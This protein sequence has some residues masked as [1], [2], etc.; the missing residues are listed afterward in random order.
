M[1]ARVR[2][3]ASPRVSARAVAGG[4]A[5]S[6][7]RAVEAALALARARVAAGAIAIVLALAAAVAP[8]VAHAQP[9]QAPAPNY[10]LEIDAPP[11]LVEPLRRQTLAGRWQNEPGFDAAQIELFVERARDEARA[12]AQAAGYF[13]A[14]ID[15]SG[16]DGTD[17]V[18]RIAVDAG[19]RATVA[20]VRIAITGAAAGTDAERALRD[21]WPL[22]EGA[23][24]RTGE[25]D[26]GKRQVLELLQSRGF[27]RA[28]IT[29]SR[30]EVDA[31]ATAASLAVEVDSGP[32]LK[33]GAL[34]V[35]GLNR[36]P[37]DIVADLRPYREGD[38]YTFERLLA[39]Q[40]LLRASGYFVG[41]SVLPD[42]AAV[43]ADPALS[44]VPIQVELLERATHDVTLGV[45]YSTDQ[46]PRG[47][48]GFEHRNLLGRGWVASSGVLV[49]AVRRRAFATVTT[50]YDDRGHRWQ[51]GARSE[52]LDVSGELTER[53]T[54]FFGRGR[55]TDE[56]EYFASLQ[57]Q[58]ERR[59]V[60]TAGDAL[61]D[62]RAALSLGYSWN[63]R[64]LDS[65]VDPRDGYTV[66][67]QL[68]GA[69]KGLG[70]DRS[71]ARAYARLMRF[72]P[73]PR[74]SSLAGGVLVG[75]VEA[76]VVVATSRD[77]IPTENL[78]RAG[79]AQSIRGYA[80]QGLGVREGDAIVG[81]RVLA[82]GSLEYQH[83]LSGNWWGAAFVDAGNA[84]DRW[85]DW[86]A[87]RGYGAGL[88]WRSPIGPVNLDVAYGDADRR[89]RAHFSVGY[90][91]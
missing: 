73:M 25:W 46:G 32:R 56:I 19:A 63:L 49:E 71:F 40:Q 80:Y 84:A 29:A 57:Y 17:P 38:D 35:R 50:P 12:I 43:E 67:A 41:V 90:S 85:A 6:P 30:A 8:P 82:L 34:S 11:E 1:P 44:A 21:A 81:G 42:L 88:R 74:D 20:R 76:G 39:Y 60:D 68:S 7:A 45:G 65:R 69:V 24:F 66:S 4:L 51:G 75:L 14:R 55:R 83:P 37:G 79:G 13:S 58:T 26:L 87:V 5:S 9:A 62:R 59:A 48:A 3:R 2:A 33:F 72:W 27:L 10:R 89:W 18:I 36:Y 53:N 54:L 91:F 16:H 78:F 23:F 70:S 28:R 22:P 61:T 31:Q 15:A 52:R 64:R 47:L 86:H 77:D